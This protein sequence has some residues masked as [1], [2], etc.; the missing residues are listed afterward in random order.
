MSVILVLSQSFFL[1]FSFKIQVQP[2]AAILEGAYTHICNLNIPLQLGRVALDE[3]K[4]PEELKRRRQRE[5]RRELASRL[6]AV[7]G[8]GGGILA[9][10]RVGNH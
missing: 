5:R 6:E 2:Y 1:N 3:A 9:V 7:G 8:S 10:V 4:V